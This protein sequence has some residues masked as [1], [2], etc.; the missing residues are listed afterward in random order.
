MEYVTLFHIN[1]IPIS[2]DFIEK[3][4]DD[5]ISRNYWKRNVIYPVSGGVKLQLHS[6]FDS[7]LRTDVMM[8][9]E[10]LKGVN[11]DILTPVQLAFHFDQCLSYITQ[12]SGIFAMSV[13]PVLPIQ[14]PTT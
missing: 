4:T 9:G 14:Q 13:E 12:H 1:I 2:N 5:F 3:I 7:V 6:H 8:H 10:H 11:L